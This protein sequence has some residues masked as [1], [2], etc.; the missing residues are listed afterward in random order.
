M[1]VISDLHIHGRFSQA[2]SKN[3]DIQN[4]VK[5]GRIKGLNLLGTGDFTHPRWIEELK[6]NLT[7]DGSGILK[8]K[9]GFPFLLQTEISLIYTQD[10]RG[11]KIHNIVLAP[12][13]ETVDQI[14]EALLKRGRIDY[15]GRPIFGIPSPEFVEIMKSVVI[16]G[17]MIGLITW[18]L[19][20][21]LSF[22]ISM[23]LLNIISQSM[24]GSSMSLTFTP[25]GVIIWLGVVVMLSI[26]ASI[27]PARNAAR[28]T[29]REV[30]AYE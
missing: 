14:T 15:D 12:D 27:L 23:L 10:G 7:E 6:T 25:Q 2:T 30:L 19:A 26:F 16:E 17:V 5:Y 24:M 1:K 18:V 20:I 11:R 9:S 28:L 13:F 22:P 8:S 21:G 4:L 29:I 3:I